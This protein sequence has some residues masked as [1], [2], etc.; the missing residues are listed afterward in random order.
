MAIHSRS[1]QVY[2]SVSPAPRSAIGASYLTA[3]PRTSPAV[4]A[5]VAFSH[6]YQIPTGAEGDYLNSSVI[7]KARAR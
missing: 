1:E 5:A 4:A 2:C 6:S 3:M 7:P